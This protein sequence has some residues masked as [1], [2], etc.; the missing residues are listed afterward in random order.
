MKWRYWLERWVDT[1][2]A[3]REDL[4]NLGKTEDFESQK[5]KLRN[6]K[7]TDTPN[8]HLPRTTHHRKTTFHWRRTFGFT[9][10]PHLHGCKPNPHEPEREPDH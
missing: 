5:V 4:Q 2:L 6:L 3:K 7:L 1:E 10:I 8:H 9:R